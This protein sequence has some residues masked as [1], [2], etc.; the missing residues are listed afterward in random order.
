MEKYK[1]CWHE[2]LTGSLFTC[3][4]SN[5]GQGGPLFKITRLSCSE[6]P[7]QYG[8]TILCRADLEE[9]DNVVTELTEIDQDIGDE[10]VYEDVI[11][12]QYFEG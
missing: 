9:H 11:G 4:V 2:K 8:Q 1:S 6:L 12:D 3:E 10:I 5:N 7:L